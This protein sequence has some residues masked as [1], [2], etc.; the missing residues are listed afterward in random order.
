MQ[1]TLWTDAELDAATA[2]RWCQVCAGYRTP[3]QRGKSRAPV[4]TGCW[5]TMTPRSDA[6]LAEIAHYKA[7]A[8]NLAPPVKGRRKS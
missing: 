3:E 6:E 2:L 4:C 1:L 8:R 7:W 5:M